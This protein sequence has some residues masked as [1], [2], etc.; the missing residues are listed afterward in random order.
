M[1]KGV[2]GKGVGGR[3]NRE[4]GTGNGERGMG[5]GMIWFTSNDVP[6]CSLIEFGMDC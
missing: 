6:N 5:H 1:C 4:G 3:G 2:R